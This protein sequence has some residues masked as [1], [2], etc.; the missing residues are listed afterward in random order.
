MSLPPPIPVLKDAFLQPMNLMVALLILSPCFAAFTKAASN[1]DCI[2]PS[3]S[4]ALSSGDSM[5]CRYENT[6]SASAKAGNET[7]NATRSVRTAPAEGRLCMQGR[8]RRQAPRDG[9]GRAPGS[10]HLAAAGAITGPNPS[11]VSEA[12]IS[13]HYL[14]QPRDAIS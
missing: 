4:L 13:S 9:A 3:H 14:L 12:S 11:S 10:T 8:A 7:M 6:G 1:I 5:A 2:S